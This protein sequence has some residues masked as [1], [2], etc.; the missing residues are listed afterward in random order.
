MSAYCGIDHTDRGEPGFLRQAGYMWGADI[1]Q[2]HQ[3]WGD[4]RLILPNV[5]DRTTEPPGREAFL[6]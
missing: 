1:S 2:V 4:V 5:D 6:K 3:A